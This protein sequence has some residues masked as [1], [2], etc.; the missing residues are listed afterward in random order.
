VLQITGGSVFDV[1]AKLGAFYDEHVRLGAER[2]KVLAANRDACLKRVSAGLAK[3]GKADWVEK[4]DQGS[5]AMHTLNQHRSNGY[6]IDVALI[7]DAADMPVNARDARLRVE[8]A[9][10]EAGGN[11]V[12]PPKARTNAVTVWYAEGHHVDLAIY[13]RTTNWLGEV[14][15]EH[16]GPA[17]AKRDPDQVTDWFAKRVVALSPTGLGV[18]VASG[19]LRRVVRLVKAFARSR[20]VWEDQLPGGMILTALVSEVFCRNASRDDVALHQTLE[21][22][23]RRLS[24]NMDVRSPV[25]PDTY[26]TA[27]P[28]V[29]AQVRRFAEKLELALTELEIL[30]DPAC[31]ERDACAAW[32]WLFRH[33]YWGQLVAA[34]DAEP[35]P[36]ADSAVQ[37]LDLEIGLA[38]A[39]QGP[40][41]RFYAG[42]VEPLRKGRWLRLRPR[43]SSP[44]ASL[45]WT[46]RNT[47]EEARRAGNE[48]WAKE[49]TG[50]LWTTAAYCGV[51]T[52]CCEMVQ[53]GRVVGRAVRRVRVGPN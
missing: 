52:V 11:F 27:K 18:A 40:V 23:R 4:R 42:P 47:G 3:F 14:V 50:E 43:T 22:L 10:L 24:A 45:H 26:L 6:D 15:L 35:P 9:L 39:E 25:A 31:T 1:S 51:H 2:R 29:A 21:A 8:A 12:K 36:D 13:R 53:R 38:A 44:G 41:E 34:A 5:Y 49:T 17:W 48:R 16:A 46:V 37:R 32:N 33:E 28:V 19:Q 7:F 30:S 20:S